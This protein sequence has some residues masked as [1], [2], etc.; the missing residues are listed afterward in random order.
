MTKETHVRNC[1]ESIAPVESDKRYARELVSDTLSRSARPELQLSLD[2]V[3]TPA[4]GGHWV[5]VDLETTGLGAGA[6]ITEIGAVRVRG[7]RVA[8]EFSSLVRPLQPIPPFITSLTGITP[9]MVEDADPIGPVLERFIEW[10]GLEGEEAPVLVAHNASFDVGFLRRAARACQRPWPRVR[11]VDTLALARL[12]LPRPL[13]RNHKLGTI[14]SYFGTSTTPEHRARGD[15][16]ATAEVLLGFVALLSSAGATDVE[17]LIALSDAAP[18]RRPATPDFVATLPTSPGVYHFVDAAGDALYVGSASSLRSRVGSYYTRA[19]KRTKVQRMV[20]LSSGVRHFPTASVLEARV[21]ELRDIATLAPPYNSASRRQ[22]NQHWVVREGNRAVVVPSVSLADLPRA[23][24]PFGTRAHATRA[25]NAIGRVVAEATGTQSAD[26]IDEA[27]AASSLTVP[28]ALTAVMARLAAQGLFEPAARARDE[29][30]A[31][32]AGVERATMRPVLSAA[33]IVWGTRRDGGEPGWLVH[34]ASYGRY[35]SSLVVPPH[36]DPTAW[37]EVASATEPLTV[38]GQAAKV[39][40]WAETALICAQLSEAGTRLIEW[41]SPLPWAQP[42]M[43]PLRDGRLR[44][45]LA[46]A[47]A[48]PYDRLRA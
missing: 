37:I 10:A 25:A 30:A 9:A 27:V 5:V 41:D 17:D 33:R 15:A 36:T 11:V 8:D 23:L 24:G 35:L 39:A 2:A 38:D 46:Q 20:S 19:E 4:S 31:Y 28:D 6:E 22:A 3:G 29:L 34:V 43:S 48:H 7:G 44:E 12:A 32:M 26:L 21:R 18:S 13:V 42:T 16:R 45:L 1:S 47:T 14:A 40:S